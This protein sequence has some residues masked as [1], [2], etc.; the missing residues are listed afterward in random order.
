MPAPDKPLTQREQQVMQ[1]IGQGL[2]CDEIAA[3]L[4]ITPLTVRKHRSNIMAKT[5]LAHSAQLRALAVEQAFHHPGHHTA[6]PFPPPFATC[7][8]PT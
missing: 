7:A 3:R 5:G 4:A 6:E 1:L 8:D 2:G